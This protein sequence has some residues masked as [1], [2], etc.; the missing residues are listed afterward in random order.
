MVEVLIAIGVILC[1]MV[2][3]TLGYVVLDFTWWKLTG[4]AG[5]FK[6]Y[7]EGEEG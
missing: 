1:I 5:G 6:D 2:P 7:L 3:L 4:H